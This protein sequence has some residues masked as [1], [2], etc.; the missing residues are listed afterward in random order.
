LSLPLSLLFA[1][2]FFVESQAV[3]SFFLFYKL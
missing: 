1:R 2:L 3:P